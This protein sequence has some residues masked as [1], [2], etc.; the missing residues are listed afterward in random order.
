MMWRWW[1]SPVEAEIYTRRKMDKK[2]F[3][4]PQWPWKWCISKSQC[5][6]FT[7]VKWWFK[8]QN[9]MDFNQERWG[10]YV[11]GRKCLLCFAD[12]EIQKTVPETW[13][14]CNK[15]VCVV[16]VVV[17]VVVCAFLCIYVVTIC[18]SIYIPSNFPTSG[19]KNSTT[20][21]LNGSNLTPSQPILGYTDPFLFY[22]GSLLWSGLYISHV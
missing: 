2:S 9:W 20:L 14:S 17:V 7:M 10:P 22:T 6:F 4:Q 16:V 21:C 19:E 11:F 1:I 13:T 8:N 15:C 18:Y 3:N 12:N 5:P